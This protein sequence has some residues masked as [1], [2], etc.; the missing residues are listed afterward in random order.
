MKRYGAAD[1]RFRGDFDDIIC[2]TE[3]RDKVGFAKKVKKRS[4]NILT[5]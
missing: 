3:N 5:L 2:E 4:A 1:T